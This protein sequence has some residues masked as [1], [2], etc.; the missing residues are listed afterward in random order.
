MFQIS[1]G[2]ET[3]IQ[4]LSELIEAVVG[5]KVKSTHSEARAGDVRRNYSLITKA[6]QV[7][8]WKPAGFSG[9]RLATDL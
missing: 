8:G 9:R 1:A 3:S 5:Q 6:E 2:T 7:L 4:T